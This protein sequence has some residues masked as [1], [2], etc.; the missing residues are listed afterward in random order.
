MVFYLKSHPTLPAYSKGKYYTA[1]ILVYDLVT[2]VNSLL[3]VVSVGLGWSL[4][5]YPYTTSKANC[6]GVMWQWILA[7][8]FRH[9]Y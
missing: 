2:T 8:H 6:L 7:L 3:N 4:L 9:L 1:L 5:H